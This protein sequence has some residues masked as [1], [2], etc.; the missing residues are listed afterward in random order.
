MATEEQAAETLTAEPPGAEDVESTSPDQS[1]RR[2]RQLKIAGILVVLTVVMMA[3]GYA[4][5]PPP[6]ETEGRT[7]AVPDPNVDSGDGAEV[8]IGEFNITKADAGIIVHVRF[9]LWVLVS[10]RQRQDFKKTQ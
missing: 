6:P 1:G 7:P 4:F 8:E 2:A 5:M 9:K 3:V 10:E